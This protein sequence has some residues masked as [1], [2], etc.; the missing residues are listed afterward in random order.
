MIKDQDSVRAMA[1]A[2]LKDGT[3]YDF[4]LN[5]AHLMSKDDL[6]RMFAELTMA[7]YSKYGENASIEIEATAAESLEG[8]YWDD[9]ED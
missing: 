4:I 8:D 9:S 6:A 5:Y 3:G 2:A 7:V 1:V